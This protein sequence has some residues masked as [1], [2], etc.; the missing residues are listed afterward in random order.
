MFTT[1]ERRFDKLSQAIESA[2]ERE[3]GFRPDVHLRS[4]EEMR[5]VISRNPFAGR[6][7]IEPSKLLVVFHA[8]EL[9]P[10]RLRAVKHAGEEFHVSGREIFIYYPDGQGKSRLSFS[11]SERGEK[12]PTGT[13]RNWNTIH[14]LLEMAEA[15][16]SRSLAASKRQ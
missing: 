9:H 11:A 16:A 10:A 7:G 12:V 13:A 5:A 3:C 4:A 6:E 14:K 2:I 8:A 15:L 1:S